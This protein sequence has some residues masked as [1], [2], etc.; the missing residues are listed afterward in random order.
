MPAARPTRRGADPL[1]SERG[2]R[3]LV[4]DDA[5]GI[6]TYLAN[7]LELRGFLR[8]AMNESLALIAEERW[9]EAADLLAI[10]DATK[11]RR[12]HRAALACNRAWCLAQLG[13][14]D[15]AVPLAEEAL[16]LCGEKQRS[17]VLSTLGMAKQVLGSSAEAVRLLEESLQRPRS[18]RARAA[19]A[20]YLGEALRSLGRIHEARAAY[21]RAFAGGTQGR[22]SHRAKQQHDAL[23]LSPQR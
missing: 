4:V 23:P 6:R 16:R 1:P 21:Q 20:F 2:R 18:T 12:F 10:V 3:V 13:R 14:G 5:E 11:L 7:L 17:T 15:E 22:Y 8:F 19:T 9:S